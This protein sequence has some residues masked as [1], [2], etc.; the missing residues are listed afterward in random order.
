MEFNNIY[1]HTQFELTCC[2]NVQ[3]HTNDKVFWSSQQIISLDYTSI[4]QKQCMDVQYKL[5]QYLTKFQILP[6]SVVKCE[7]KIK[8]TAFAFH[9]SYSSSAFPSYISGVHHFWVRFLHMWPFSNPITTVVTFRLRGWWVL[10][11]FVAGIHPSGT[12][13][14][15]SFESMWRNA[16]VHRLDLG[17]YSH[18]KE[19]F[20]EWSSNPC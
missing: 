1:H 17:L 2:I 9:Q 13:T 7:T 4:T 18:L 5:H 15:G 8:S 14:S 20:G 16:C 3:M 10:G 11:V 6:H 19:F 12:W